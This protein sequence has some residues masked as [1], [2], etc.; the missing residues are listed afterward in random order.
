MDLR[1]FDIVNPWRKGARPA[2]PPIRRT[3]LDDLLRNIDSGD[4]SVVYGAR[5]VGKSTLLRAAIHDLL[6]DRAVA[7]A[8]IFFFDLDTM[9]CADVLA[10]PSSLVDFIG[11]PS[12][13]VYVFIDE[14]QRL[15]SPGLFLKGIHDL[16]LP[17]RLAVS[18]SS[19][20][21]IRS[22]I[23]ETL[24]GRKRLIHLGGLSWVECTAHTALTWNDF[25]IYGSYPGVALATD[26]FEKRRLL[27]EYFESYM[28]RDI[29]SFL[30]VDRMDVFRDF[31]RLLGFQ[32]GSL[33]N[34]HEMSS[35]LRVA[36]DTL[37]RYLGY[38]EKTF[39]V[40]RAMPFSRNARVEVTKMPKI[41]F[42]DCGWRN[43]ASTGFTGWE[44]RADGGP[45]LETAVEH[46]LRAAYP[47]AE[48]RFWRT[49]AK[50]EVDFVVDDGGQLHAFEVEAQALRRPTVSRSLRSFIQA[51]KPATAAV[52]NLH[53][54]SEVD[55]DGVNVRF[56]AFPGCTANA[57]QQP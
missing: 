1:F 23:R 10:T 49:Q 3:V 45:L 2:K 57:P 19:S 17:I 34:L 40:R 56:L 38:L 53:L 11:M 14:I 28:D 51:Y 27:L 42:T 26:P 8:H 35:T 16:G 33:V 25:L 7:P 15:P 54:E 37:A 55:V 9:D 47:L 20:L 5:R 48:I 46:W 52:I 29:V 31:V 6:A 18:G 21:E 32:S 39:V 36:R 12:R 43:L 4:I 50:A 41:Y 24:S 30:R 44:E 13:P 22:K